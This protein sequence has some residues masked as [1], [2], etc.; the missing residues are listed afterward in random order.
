MAQEANRRADETHLK[1]T[2]KGAE[3]VTEGQSS[4]QE[5]TINDHQATMNVSSE[6]GPLSRAD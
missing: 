4:A 2:Q 1:S 6:E 3:E 5:G